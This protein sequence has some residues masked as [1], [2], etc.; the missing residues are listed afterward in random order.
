MKQLENWSI[1]KKL[2][3]SFSVIMALFA[4]AMI[5][6]LVSLNSLS[7]NVNTLAYDAV[8]TVEAIWKGRRAMVAVE[9]ALYMA[10]NS[11]TEDKVKQYVTD[12]ETQMGIIREEVLPL[13]EENYGGDRNIL[14]QYRSIMESV[15]EVKEQIYNLML[16]GDL[17]GGIKLL[18]SDY[19][20]KF[21][22][23]ATL[24]AQM[25][26][27]TQGRVDSFA[28]NANATNTTMIIVLLAFLLVGL[29][30]AIL[31]AFK[32]TAS[33]TRP[34]NEIQEAAQFM[35]AGNYD[36]ALTYE[37][38]NELGQLSANIRTMADKTREVIID[39]AR[40]LKEVAQ[41]NFNISPKADYVGVFA[42]IKIALGTIII[43]LSETMKNI[44]ESADQVA[45]G[46]DQIAHAAQTLSEGASDQASAV[47]ELSATITETREKASTGAVQA[48][49]ATSKTDA[50]GQV[51]IECSNHMNNMLAAMQDIQKA[52]EEISKIINNIESIASQTNLLSLNAAIEAARAGE[53]G[54]GF[55]VV[56][57]EVRT[58]AEESSQ[59]VK[60]TENLIRKTIDAVGKGTEIA[61]LT[62][63]TLN[64]VKERTAEI[65]TI[66]KQMAVISEDQSQ[67]LDQ[68]MTAVDQ[69]TRVVQD[70]SAASQ[71]TAASSEELS[72]QSQT[73]KELVAQFQLIDKSKKSKINL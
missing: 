12:A 31:I 27:D 62:A 68:I 69:I 45:E 46:S 26:S 14:V 51:V 25:T 47:E 34:I 18:E 52:S 24:L 3:I 59:A 73:L 5:T 32:L 50:T 61:G 6:A 53:A 38:S 49:S 66:V 20:P 71:E 72:A 7:S 48:E 65:G 60:D 28:V 39:T 29:A 41:G 10:A 33:I 37:S 19:T 63:E 67:S 23:A 44:T 57:D 42:E 13:L 1:R 36:I 2:I 8:P 35:A 40:G 4:A 11:E 54:R 70:N 30:A 58:L 15:K 43:Q 22:E 21:V 17:K 16:D 64:S 9:R 56:A 55:A